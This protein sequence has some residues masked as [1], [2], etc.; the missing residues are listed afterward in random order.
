MCKKLIFLASFVLVLALVHS[1]WGATKIIVVNDNPANEEG[2]EPLLKGILGNDIAVEIEDK[3]YRDTL[4]DAAKADLSSADLIIVSRGTSSGSYGAEIEFWN[5]LETPILLHSAYLSRENRWRWL[6]G[7]QHDAD[8]L[9]HVAVVD[10]GNLIFDG[11]TVIDGQVEIFPSPFDDT[12]VST[13]DSAGNGTL[14]ATPAG[15]TDVMI[16]SWE[17]GTEY[18]PGS[19]QIAG[20]PRIAF[21]MRKPIDSFP[22]LTADGKKMLENA[23]SYTL[24]AAG[25][26]GV[27]IPVEAGGDIAA[28]NALAQAGD[29]IDIAAGTFVLAEQIEIKDGVTY[30]GA[31]ADL[32]VIDGG[33]LTRAFFAWG[34]RSA[35]D[36]QVDANGVS[37]PNATGPTG[38]VLDGMTIQNCVSDIDNRQDILGAARDLL[39][40]Y[41]GA[42]YTLATAQGENGGITDNPGW[43]DILSGSADDN[44]TDAEL[45]AYLDANPVGSAGHIVVN[46]DKDDDGGAVNLNN[47]AAG[48]IRN[49]MFSNIAAVNDGGAIEVNGR[50]TVAIQNCTFSNNSS[51]DDGGAISANGSGLDVSIE[52]CEFNSCSNNDGDDGGALF[53]S[54]NESTY[55]VTDSSFTGCISDDDG[56]VAYADGHDSSYAFSNCT[57]HLNTCGDEGGALKLSPQ[58]STVTLT[59]I[60]FTEN[61]AGDDAGALRTD[62]DDSSFVITGC[63]FI[64]NTCKDDWAAWQH[65]TDRAELTMTNCSFISNG[66]DAEGAVVGDDSV[67]GLDD[68][69]AGPTTFENCLFANNACNDDW[70][71]ELKAAL[72]M[73]NCTFIGNASA[74]SSKSMIGVRGRPWNSTGDDIDDVVT[75]VSIISNCLFINNT[76][77]KSVIGDTYTDVFAPTVTNCLFYGNLDDGE[78]AANTDDNSPEVGTIDVSAVTDAAQIVVDPAGDYH[79][80]A[81]SPAIDASDPATATAADI[82]GTPAVGV[83]DVGA[84]EAP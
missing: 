12:D 72:T 39:N 6:Q 30:Q 77:Q 24:G 33:S 65:K 68:D 50:A 10:E 3:K 54:G 55:I 48:T 81:G 44:L 8:A 7:D 25:P 64:G 61:Y 23:V 70:I 18:Y 38:W 84:Y 29:T 27:T 17:P 63:S 80:A 9:T 57:L 73:V 47:G 36:G 69:D 34:D 43:F 15:S 49:C 35:T 67:L 71:M 32:T 76:T 52:N 28:A 2:L 46:G 56:G 58:R 37:V 62:G 31:G 22:T 83:R 53:L 5:G 74:D 51:N 41:T 40:N 26:A 11:V 78:P 66:L 21:L 79:L 45:Q 42:P 1:G 59:D 75:N 20:G 13:Q 60:I 16:A 19:G 14:I 82:E 4:S